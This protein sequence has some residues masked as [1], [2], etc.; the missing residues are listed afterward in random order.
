MFG[1]VSVD[2]VSVLYKEKI[3]DFGFNGNGA[4]GYAAE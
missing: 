2:F 1:Y 3:V 4:T